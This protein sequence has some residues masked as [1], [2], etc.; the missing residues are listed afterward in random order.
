[1]PSAMSWLS[2][3]NTCATAASICSGE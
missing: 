2:T 3:P 1:V